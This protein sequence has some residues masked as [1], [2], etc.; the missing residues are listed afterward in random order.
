MRDRGM[1]MTECTVTLKLFN[2]FRVYGVLG[3]G[4]ILVCAT[5]FSLADPKP[6]YGPD[7][8]PLST[9]SN[10]LRSHPAGD[11]WALM[12]YYTAQQT[13]SACSIASVTMVMNGLRAGQSL[14]ADDELISQNLL[15][16]KVKDSAWTKA[17]GPKGEGASLDQLGKYISEALRAYGFADG[18]KDPKNGSGYGVEVWHA[19]DTSE[20]SLNQLEKFLSENESS[21]KNFIIINFLQGV[22][23]GDALAGHIAPLGEYDRVH[24]RVLILDPDRQWY[25]PYW[26]STQVLLKSMATLDKGAGKNRGLVFIRTKAQ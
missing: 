24:R 3:L 10:Y 7:A 1:V 23:T 4:L 16:A 22:A 2:K 12:P 5:H 26:V 13:G 15:L 9:D 11:F 8:I 18:S 17:V 14:T 20:E 19:P 6:K 25:E 21:A